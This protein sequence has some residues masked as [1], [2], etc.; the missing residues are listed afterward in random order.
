MG[1]GKLSFRLLLALAG[2][3]AIL[4]LGMACDSATV[5]NRHLSGDIIHSLE[6]PPQVP[7]G[8]TVIMKQTIRNIGDEAVS[9]DLP[10]PYINF[11]VE[12]SDGQYV[13]DWS[14]GKA[15][16]SDISFKNLE[17]SDEWVF[18]AEWEQVDKRGE[19]VPPGT[20]LVRGYLLTIDILQNKYVKYW[21]EA[22]E[23]EVLRPLP[24][25]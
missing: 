4:V 24:S 10:G 14:S 19:P 22:L 23:L 2:A 17:P 3:A 25:E 13:W 21:T 9:F 1:A 12:T 11:V 8:D 15:Y 20:Y 6:I 7:Y 16:F 18:I 5:I